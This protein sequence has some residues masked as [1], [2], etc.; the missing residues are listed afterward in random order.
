MDKGEV[1]ELLKRL[2][3]QQE[4][5]LETFRQVSDLLAQ[6]LGS[7]ASPARK[8]GPPTPDTPGPE[9]R[10][11]R[12]STHSPRPSFA[13]GASEHELQARKISAGIATLTTSS[14]S[15]KTGEDSDAD[16]DEDLYVSSTLAPQKHDED[17][18]RKHL[19]SYQWT[20]YDAR[21]LETV[22]NNPAR[23]LQHPLIP[24]RKGPSEDRSQYSH[25]QVFDV[26]PDGAPLEVEWDHV[27]RASSRPHAI[28][29]AIRELNQPPKER[30]AVG[31]ITIMREPSPILFGALHHTL[32][33][34]FDMDELFRHLVQ[35]EAS[36]ADMF[37]AFD[38]DPRRQR[39][40]VFNF[41]YFTVRLSLV[42][43]R[44]QKS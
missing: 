7:T 29:Y 17:T 9:P 1:S 43:Y 10:P 24:T 22:I 5:Y 20:V 19:Q 28:W 38:D 42:M 35:A 30:L 40:F 34:S 13:G 2:D 8:T 15:R 32:C 31:R 37:R 14:E 26:G 23:I 21:I 33:Q 16:E 6:N 36:S 12:C 44:E 39:S 41:E 11:S 25:C 18:L 3:A 4:A 27:E